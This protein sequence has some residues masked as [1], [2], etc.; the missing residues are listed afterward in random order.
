MQN[1]KDHCCDQYLDCYKSEPDSPTSHCDARRVGDR[2]VV[3]I[4]VD[5]STAEVVGAIR[6]TMDQ[7]NMMWDEIEM[8]EAERVTRVRRFYENIQEL[9]KD[10]VTSEAEMVGSVKNSIADWLT[11]VNR[12]RAELHLSP[13]EHRNCGDNPIRLYHALKKERASLKSLVEDRLKG[14]REMVD[15]IYSVAVRLG[16]EVGEMPGV[17]VLSG[18]WDN[19]TLTIVQRR[20]AE[21]NAEL[22]EL[23]DRASQWQ[24]D[25][26]RWCSQMGSQWGTDSVRQFANVALD[27]AHLVLDAAFMEEFSEAHSLAMISY[28]EW[29]QQAQLDYQRAASKLEELWELYHVPDGERHLV[30]AFN[31]TTSTATDIENIKREVQK[32]ERF[33]EER[34]KIYD[35]IREWKDLWAEK[36]GYESRANDVKTYINRGGRLQQILQRQRYI[37]A[38]IPTVLN[39]LKEEAEKYNTAHEPQDAFLIDGQP[40]WKHIE[41]IMSEYKAHKELQRRHKVTVWL[42][43]LMSLL[44]E[45]V[46]VYGFRCSGF[47]NVICHVASGAEHTKNI[48]SASDVSIEVEMTENSDHSHER[49]D[50]VVPY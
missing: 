17:E 5:L 36:I 30:A 11:E 19:E 21:M 34:L 23:L 42:S 2:L 46:Q 22:T 47:S 12:M 27:D 38:R 44:H 35:K 4:S 49:H 31:P 3:R 39:E 48:T 10:I 29:L 13:F 25:L 41:W 20:S 28:N 37:A 18:V 14:Q 24:T 45:S 40:P 50:A 26:R 8:Q 43:S 7:L 9:I 33:L 1:T 15:E 32:L 16:K 6:D